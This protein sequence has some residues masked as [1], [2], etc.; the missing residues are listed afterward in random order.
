MSQPEGSQASDASGQ[1][2]TSL[3][4][5][6]ADPVA[7]DAG[8][9]GEIFEDVDVNADAPV[10]E[11]LDAASVKTLALKA[12]ARLSFRARPLHNV[13]PAHRERFYE[14]LQPAF[15]PKPGDTSLEK[16]AGKNLKIV[17]KTAAEARGYHQPSKHRLGDGTVWRNVEFCVPPAAARLPLS[18]N[19]TQNDRQDHEDWELL[20]TVLLPQFVE[21]P[22]WSH[23]TVVRWVDEKS[24]KASKLKRAVGKIPYPPIVAITHPSKPTGPAPLDT[25]HAGTVKCVINDSFSDDI[26]ARVS[27]A[28]SLIV[29]GTHI[30]PLGAILPAGMERADDIP[31]GPWSRTLTFSHILL[32][33]PPPTLSEVYNLPCITVHIAKEGRASSLK[34]TAD[35]FTK[36]TEFLTS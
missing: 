29:T 19:A 7:L 12:L 18:D 15:R 10:E 22:N 24:G 3:G 2:H 9:Q 20:K 1:T 27:G 11:V 28:Q 17:T 33:H 23:E 32:S 13:L 16:E 25:S 36:I 8:Q 26:S 35:G 21:N 6:P 5:A 31:A 4:S 34:R 14:V 30:P